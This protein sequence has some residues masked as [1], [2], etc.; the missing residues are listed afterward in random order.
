MILNRGGVIYLEWDT[1]EKVEL[2]TFDILS[3]KKG[4]EYTTEIHVSRWKYGW[5]FVKFGVRQILGIRKRGNEDG[6]V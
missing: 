1:G 4:T 6:K 2:G 3:N 5:E